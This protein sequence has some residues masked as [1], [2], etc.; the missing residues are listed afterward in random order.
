MH[1]YKLCTSYLVHSHRPFDMCA[2]N[3]STSHVLDFVPFDVHFA[4]VSLQQLSG[5]LLDNALR[6]GL[7]VD[8]IL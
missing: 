3:E 8:G 5:V 7:R 6:L 4:S 1:K 2:Q